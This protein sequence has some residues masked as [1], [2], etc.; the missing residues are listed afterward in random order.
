M[1]TEPEPFS[2]GRRGRWRRWDGSSRY[3]A[4]VAHTRC[5]LSLF[6]VV[7]ALLY[8]I[9]LKCTHQGRVIRCLECSLLVFLFSHASS[10]WLRLQPNPI[11]AGRACCSGR[12]AVL[13]LLLESS[14][15][16]H[17][18]FALASAAVWDLDH[19]HLD[20]CLQNRSCFFCFHRVP[21]GE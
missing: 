3:F 13:L 6:P 20:V 10:C 7:S 17:A 5:A 18:P 2:I 19:C 8:G 12:T 14:I 11:K 15:R 21:P 16:L 9:V 1:K 4:A